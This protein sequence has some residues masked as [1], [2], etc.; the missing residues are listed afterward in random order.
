MI[1]V[2]LFALLINVDEPE[3][4]GMANIEGLGEVSLPL[5]VWMLEQRI[6]PAGNDINQDIFVL[7]RKGDRIERLTFQFVSSEDKLPVAS[8]FDSICMAT[9][10]GVPQRI[11]GNKNVHDIGHTL[12]N[13]TKMQ[14]VNGISNC[15]RCLNV[16]TS[17]T[18]PNWM[19]YS[20]VG[21]IDDR[22]VICVYASP[23]VLS[24]EAFE[25][26]YICSKLKPV[27]HSE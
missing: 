21:E 16:Y 9:S 23:S 14:P 6:N 8:Y 15:E 1:I 12:I 25:D 22:I 20:F 10:N 18:E 17:D 7:K 3:Y 27:R 26:V 4:R 24:P 5:G 19:A 13:P 2:L 11:V